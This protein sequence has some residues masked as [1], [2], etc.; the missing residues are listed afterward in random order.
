MGLPA[1]DYR[2]EPPRSARRTAPKRGRGTSR[3]AKSAGRRKKKA[4]AAPRS[5]F[6]AVSCV[7]CALTIFGVGRVALAVQATETSFDAGALR[8][9]IKAERLY[10][11]LLEVDKSA[12][13]TPSRIEAI[14]GSTMSM[15]DAADVDY[16]A[17]PEQAAAEPAPLPAQTD[18]PDE[19]AVAE[20]GG[21]VGALMELAAEEAQVLLVGD[22]GLASPR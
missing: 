11:D 21:V 7:L 5:I 19:V 4:N 15:A 3:P 20:D 9:D 22:V 17:L 10:G 18:G 6:I 2:K 14:A 1:I 13:T 12:L 16:L 8:E